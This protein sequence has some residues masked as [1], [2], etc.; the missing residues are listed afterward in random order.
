[1][2]A[3]DDKPA[4]ELLP[5]E[6]SRLI[7]NAEAYRLDVERL[8][9]ENRA[10]D[11]RIARLEWLETA[12]PDLEPLMRLVEAPHYRAALRAIEDEKLRYSK[13]GGRLLSTRAWVSLWLQQSGRRRDF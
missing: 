10:K 3:P 5:D 4:P 12:N 11:A 8:K 2:T 1:M 13:F 9:A 7:A 6:R